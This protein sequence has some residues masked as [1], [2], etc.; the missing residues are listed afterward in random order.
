R[1]WPPLIYACASKLHRASARQS[2]GI[3]EC[4]RL[5]LDHGVDPNTSV[6][7]DPLDPETSWPAIFRAGISANIPVVL[8]LIHRG[9]ALDLKQLKV[10]GEQSPEW[11]RDHPLMNPAIMKCLEAAEMRQRLS[12]FR[13]RAKGQLP[14]SDKWWFHTAPD[15][16]GITAY[17]YRPLLER[18]C[19]PN[20]MG[21]DGLTIFQHIARRGNSESVE[22]FLERGA[23]INRTAPDGRT[24]LVLAVRAGNPLSTG[25]LRA[26][27]ASDAGLRPIDE[28]VG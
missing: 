21:L 2:S 3:R 8:L 4:V 1:G 15:F 9:A 17:A 7:N 18:G 23:H 5:L 14:G 25:V 20:R 16:S 13:D 19:D 11:Q 24:P 27:G 26:H 22:R 10:G 28:L 12:E 6:L